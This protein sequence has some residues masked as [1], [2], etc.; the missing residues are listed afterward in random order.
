MSLHGGKMMCDIANATFT[1]Y[2]A[3]TEQMHLALE[4]DVIWW[5]WNYGDERWYREISMHRS[6]TGGQCGK[7][8]L[9]MRTLWKVQ[10]G[11][12]KLYY[13]RCRFYTLAH[14]SDIWTV[15]VS[16]SYFVSSN[17]TRV[18]S[19]GVPRWNGTS[20]KSGYW[21]KCSQVGAATSTLCWIYW[22]PTRPQKYP[23]WRAGLKGLNLGDTGDVPV[24]RKVS[25]NKSLPM[26]L[27]E[28]ICTLL[29]CLKNN[30]TIPRSLVKNGKRDREYLA[31]SRVSSEVWLSQLQLMLFNQ[32]NRILQ[33]K[34]PLNKWLCLLP[35]KN[36]TIKVK[37]SL[38]T[39]K[40]DVALL[41]KKQQICTISCTCHIFI[42]CK[43][44]CPEDSLPSLI[45]CL[46]LC[47]TRMGSGDYS[48]KAKIPKVCLYDAIS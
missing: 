8:D 2:L 13:L 41:L 22:S 12:N 43:E 16:S 39:L 38:S 4:R 35:W 32:Y 14:V 3:R 10:N 17:S 45:S 30:S 24:S 48:W 18:Y 36:W 23:F 5:S 28:D 26:K 25:K 37:D 33:P 47:A 44:A 9:W 15:C 20:E 31:N 46:I 34:L 42:K 27:S 7:S 11:W 29:V 40:R 19:L 6:A 1:L 21:P